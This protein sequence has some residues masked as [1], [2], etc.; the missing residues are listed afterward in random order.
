MFTALNITGLKPATFF[1]LVITILA[2]GE[3]LL[4]AGITLPHVTL[5]NFSKNALPH[6]FGGILASVPFAIWFF[7]AIEGVA[8]LAEETVNPQK[9]IRIALGWTI[10]TLVVL[11]VLTFISAVGVNG[12]ESIVYTSPGQTSDSPLPMA[13]ARVSGSSPLMYHLLVG[14]GLLGLVASFHGII[15]A[16][17][18]ATFEFGRVGYAPAW[19]GMIH[20]RFKTP[21]AALVLNMGMGIIAL[22]SGKTGEIIT[23]ACFGAITLYILSLVSLFSLRRN[24][25]HMHRPFQVPLYPWFPAIALVLACVAMLAMCIYN[26]IL[27]FIYAAMLVLAYA[28]FYFLRKKRLKFMNR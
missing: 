26:I 24:N 22:L 25:P 11:C 15:L 3:L 6:G 21:A 12:W 14:I 4:F 7:L 19:L 27:A 5:S 16:A 8:N 28:G 13:L 10:M 9:N 20:S 1:E 18:R 23:L 2:I 17:G